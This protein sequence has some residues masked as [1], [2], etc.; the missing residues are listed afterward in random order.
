L[1]GKTDAS[2][3]SVTT[4]LYSASGDLFRLGYSDGTTAVTYTNWNRAG[5][6]R[7]LFDASGEH[8]LT[9]DYASR[10]VSDYCPSGLVAG[11]TVAHHFHPQYGRDYLEVS[12]SGFTVHHDF[13]HDTYGRLNMVSNGA[14]AAIYGYLPKATGC[15]PPPST[16]AARR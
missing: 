3:K 10:L 11:V 5:Q 7:T 8:T 16:A 9:Y 6:P 13:G 15:K 4:N 2:G 12:G 1:L 14:Q